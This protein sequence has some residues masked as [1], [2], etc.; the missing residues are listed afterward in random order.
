MT[1]ASN[2]SGD[3]V[4][5]ADFDRR[6][7]PDRR[8]RPT[9]MFSRYTF[10]GRRRGSRRRTEDVSIYVDR[11]GS[12]A[13]SLIFLVLALSFV[14]AVFTLRHLAA[15]GLEANPIMSAAIEIGPMA[16]FVI[17]TLL[18]VSGMLLLVLHK[19][20]R[21]VTVA[22]GAVVGLYAALTGYHLY[23]LATL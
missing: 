21:G 6:G 16:F 15:G 12:R 17:K 23:L 7:G 8:E 22:M 9:P 14:D 10:W 5:A 11:H 20:F 1:I 18:T 3:F 19:N 4:P 13:I 2:I